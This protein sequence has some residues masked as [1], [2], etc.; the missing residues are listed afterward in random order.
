MAMEGMPCNA[1]RNRVHPSVSGALSA[2]TAAAL[3]LSNPESA[4][5]TFERTCGIE[6]E[7]ARKDVRVDIGF[8][9]RYCAGDEHIC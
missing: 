3:C 6:V 9:D 7:G 8:N 4:Y 2:C 5:I 1:S